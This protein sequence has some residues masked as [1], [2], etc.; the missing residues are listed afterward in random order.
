MAHVRTTS[1]GP[2][3]APR[4]LTC[5]SLLSSTRHVLDM[6]CRQSMRGDGGLTYGIF[7]P[8]GEVITALSGDVHR[9]DL[10]AFVTSGL[11][12]FC[13]EGVVAF[14]AWG[15]EALPD[16]HTMYVHISLLAKARM[17]PGCDAKIRGVAKPL[18]L[19]IRLPW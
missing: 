9:P 19:V 17:Q 5:F 10:H 16:M 4:S 15:I 14:A 8:V 11:F 12:S 6:R 1:C 7:I 3:G 18:A 2:A 13:I